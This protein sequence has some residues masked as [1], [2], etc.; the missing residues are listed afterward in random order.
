MTMTNPILLVEDDHLDVMTFKRAMRELQLEYPLAVASTG[1]EALAWLEN[2]PHNLPRV[3]LLDLNMPRM[4]GIEVLT[5]MKNHPI[6]RRVP[7]VILTTSSQE[8]ERQQCFDLSAA[9]Y[10]VKPLE[11][12]AFVQIVSVICAYWC[13]NQL[14]E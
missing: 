8:Q 12:S 2:H 10:I 1:E 9:G 3:M 14:A 4:N 6:W 13:I 11:Y 7:V 5:A